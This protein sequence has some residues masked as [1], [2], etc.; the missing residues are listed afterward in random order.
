MGSLIDKDGV[1]H[2]KGWDGQY[3]PKQGWF[4]PE[5]E[6][7]FWGNPNIERDFFGNPKVERDWLG[8]SSKS[9]TGKSLFRSGEGGSSSRSSSGS[10]SLDAS[11][12][13]FFIMVVVIALIIGVAIFLLI[14]M[15]LFI[16]LWHG[17]S[18]ENGR[19]DLRVF[20]LTALCVTGLTTL[21]FFAWE[22]II[23]SYHPTWQRILFP[24]LTV[25]GWTGFGWVVT[26][27][28]W[29]NPM[30][31]AISNV[32]R[33]YWRGMVTMWDWTWNLL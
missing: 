33:G 22:A 27:K 6:K 12:A 25:G 4:G 17:L 32:S 5:K 14:I 28:G 16:M 10:D 11:L 13:W 1:V 26:A 15:P 20:V 31:I 23:Y 18:S 9:S 30:W 7:D 8:R 3:R 2:E 21:S 19:K 29:L 24:L